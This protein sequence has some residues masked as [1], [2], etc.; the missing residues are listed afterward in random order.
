VDNTGR[1]DSNLFFHI[2][3]LIDRNVFNENYTV[4]RCELFAGKNRKSYFEALLD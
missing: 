2:D 1:K 3:R 4:E